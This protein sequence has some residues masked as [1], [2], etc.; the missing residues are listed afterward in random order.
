MA[1]L[2]TA[3]LLEDFKASGL[4]L[5]RSGP[6]A[7]IERVAPADT[8]GPGD[9]VFAEA[10]SYLQSVLQRKPAAVVTSACPGCA[11]AR[12]CRGHGKERAPGSGAD[13]AALLR[14]RSAQRRVAAHPSE[15]SGPRDRVHP[16]VCHHRPQC[17]GR[18]ARPS[19]PALRRARRG[20][21]RARGGARG[22]HRRPPQCRHRLG[23]RDRPPLHHQGRCRDRLRRLRLRPGR[24]SA[25]TTGCLSSGAW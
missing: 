10:A 6:D 14:S 11:A 13:P 1:H 23:M 7:V 3:R 18:R 5:D 19:G 8:C 16:R 9:L 17:R 20:H 25:T 24:R 12:R 21:R 22:G 15:R 2:T 4:L